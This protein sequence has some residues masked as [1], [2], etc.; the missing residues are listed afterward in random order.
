MI[1]AP[2]LTFAFR[3][4][5]DDGGSSSSSGCESNPLALASVTSDKHVTEHDVLCV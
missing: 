5:D 4:S 2:L 1:A 3:Y